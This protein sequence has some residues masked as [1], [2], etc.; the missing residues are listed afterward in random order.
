[1]D[2]YGNYNGQEEQD[3]LTG[4]S[5]DGHDFLGWRWVFKGI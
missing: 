1:M 2:G 5:C 4:Y 3:N